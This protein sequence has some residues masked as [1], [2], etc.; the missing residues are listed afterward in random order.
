[1][2][3]GGSR[4]DAEAPD[5]FFDVG[6][7]RVLPY[8][9]HRGIRSIDVVINTHPHEDHLQGLVAIL[10]ERRVGWAVD[11]GDAFASITWREYRE[12]IEERGVTYYRAERFDRIELEPGIALE[13]LHPPA[14]W[15]GNV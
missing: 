9:K 5:D 1:V 3:G 12:L 8:L 10:R 6:M 7:R 2:D 11:A 14:G 15:Q 4:R 13:V